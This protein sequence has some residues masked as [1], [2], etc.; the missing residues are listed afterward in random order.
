MLDKSDISRPDPKHS[1]TP[2]QEPEKKLCAIVWLGQGDAGYQLGLRLHDV[3]I[4][5]G[6][7]AD[8]I[9]MPTA[10]R[11]FDYFHDAPKNEPVYVSVVNKDGG[12]R[13]L[14]ALAP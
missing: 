6:D 14:K 3:I 8:Q 1:C 11:F 10:R 7:G 12:I 2:A 4:G 13:N 9:Q 5:I